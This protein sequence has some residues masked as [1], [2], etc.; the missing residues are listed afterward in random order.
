MAEPEECR[1]TFANGSKGNYQNFYD[2]FKVFSVD[3]FPAT[4]TAINFYDLYDKEKLDLEA[5]C[6]EI[7]ELQ[8]F[9]PD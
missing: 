8:D 6:P 3:P 9:K 1:S 4:A 7:G 2:T 5:K